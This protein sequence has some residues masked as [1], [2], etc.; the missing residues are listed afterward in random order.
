MVQ[1]AVKSTGSQWGNLLLKRKFLDRGLRLVASIVAVILII[2][3]TLRQNPKDLL[4]AIGA[5]AAIFSLIFRDIILGFIASL[6]VS[7]QDMI[8][9]GDWVEIPSKNTNGFVS[10]INVMNIIVENFDHSISMIPTYPLISESFVNWRN[11]VEEGEGRQFKRPLYI[12]IN[13]ISILTDENP[14]LEEKI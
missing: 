3:I 5:S 14:D 7:A 11:M 9:P 6:Q 4:V 8:R 12:D 10:E 1:A 2:S 13:N